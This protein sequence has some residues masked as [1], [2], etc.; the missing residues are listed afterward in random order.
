MWESDL[1][2]TKINSPLQ[3]F[4]LTERKGGISSNKFFGDN[5]LPLIIF[6]RLS[7]FSSVLLSLRNLK[8]IF[9]SFDLFFLY[10]SYLEALELNIILDTVVYR[11]QDQDEA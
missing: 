3:L 2:F 1:V 9:P 4:E 6:R 11:M 8:L 10:F 7:L 5:W